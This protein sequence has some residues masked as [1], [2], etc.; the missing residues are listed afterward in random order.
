M[1][2]ILFLSLSACLFASCAAFVNI[3]EPQKIRIHTPAPG[4]VSVNNEARRIGKRPVTFK[5]A[6]GTNSFTIRF[7]N[8]SANINATIHPNK[9]FPKYVYPRTIFIDTAAKDNWQTH[10]PIRRG[11]L[12]LHFSL[13]YINIFEQRPEGEGIKYNTGFLGI[14][15]GLDYYHSKSQYLS[16]TGSA[17]MDLMLPFPAPIDYFSPHEQMYSTYLS[18]TNNHKIGRF[19]LGYGLA[20]GNNLWRFEDR[21]VGYFERKSNTFLGFSAPVYCRI[22]RT[23]H[24]GFIYRPSFLN[25]NTNKFQYEHLMS[26]DL[27][28]KF[29][30]N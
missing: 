7:S 29:A 12:L 2:P 11:L 5:I 25:L 23:F 28:W 1:R 16:L 18:L 4:T 13:P 10:V 26:I 22:G 19:S 6:P 3:N 20:Y 30:L 24:L 9:S 27:A 8:D 17:A 14:S 21:S 15:T